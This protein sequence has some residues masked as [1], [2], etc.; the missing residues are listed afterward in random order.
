MNQE[1]ADK[2][3][4]WICWRWTEWL[5]PWSSSSCKNKIALLMKKFHIIFFLHQFLWL[6]KVKLSMCFIP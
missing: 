3:K 1:Q 4:P 6:V 2:P 5:S